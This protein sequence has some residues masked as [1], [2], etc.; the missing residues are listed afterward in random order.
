MIYDRFVPDQTGVLTFEDCS[1]WRLGPTNDEGWWK[2]QCRYSKIAPEWGEFYK[3]S[4]DGDLRIAPRDWHVSMKQFDE[5][6]LRHFLFYFRDNTFECLAR[7][8]SFAPDPPP[9]EI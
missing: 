8:W 2:N 6:S 5:K 1:R 7:D 3:I 9:T 4:G